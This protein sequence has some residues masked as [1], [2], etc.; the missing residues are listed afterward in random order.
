MVILRVVLFIAALILILV[1]G[2]WIAAMA[3]IIIGGQN[4]DEYF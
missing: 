2:I 3:G 1:V 4:D